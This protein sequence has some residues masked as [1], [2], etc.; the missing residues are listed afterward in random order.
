MLHLLVFY[1]VYVSYNLCSA[2][3]KS[4]Y[5]STFTALVQREHSSALLIP[6]S[7]HLSIPQLYDIPFV[8]SFVVLS[9]ESYVL[10]YGRLVHL[11]VPRLRER[12]RYSYGCYVDFPSVMDE[13]SIEPP[14]RA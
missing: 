13:V 5:V 2:N 11:E 3:G 6:H 8:Y 9:I 4:V 10:P 1:I 12:R 7:I 14:L